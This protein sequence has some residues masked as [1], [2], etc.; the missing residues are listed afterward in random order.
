ML[1]QP[2]VAQRDVALLEAERRKLHKLKPQ[3]RKLPWMLEAEGE[4]EPTPGAR[5]YYP[6][7][8][9]CCTPT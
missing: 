5:T 1:A 3:R 8:R 7:R 2:Y 9:T 6:Y 4:T